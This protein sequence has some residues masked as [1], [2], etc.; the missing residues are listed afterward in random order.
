M[1]GG[2]KGK[3]ARL[4]AV[5]KEMAGPPPSFAPSVLGEGSKKSAAPK[6]EARLGKCQRVMKGVAYILIAPVLV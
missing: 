6:H 3:E 1:G 5:E 2:Q 4:M